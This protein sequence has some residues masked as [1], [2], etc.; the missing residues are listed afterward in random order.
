[1]NVI[2]FDDPKRENLLPFTYTRPASELRLGIYTIREK[3][4]NWLSLKASNFTEDYLSRKFPLKT[5]DHNLMINGR[6]LPSIELLHQIK[7]LK[8]NE[9]VVFNGTLVAVWITEKELITFKS[10][11]LPGKQSIEAKA[12]IIEVEYPWHIFQ[13]NGDQI[14]LDYEW[15]CKRNRSL[16]I[17]DKHTRVYCPENVFLEEGASVKAAILNA[18]NGPIYLGKNST[19]EEGVIIKGPFALGDHSTINMN[20]RMRG[21]ISVG[22]HCKVG[23]EVSNSVFIA[24]SNKGHDGFLGNSVIGEWCNLGA[25]TN[26]SN[27]KNNY[28]NVKLWNFGE[29]RFVDTGLTFCGLM[30]GDHTKCGINTMFNTGTIT[31]VSANIFGSGFPRTLI[32][33]FAW[34][35]SSGFSTFQLKKAFET[36]EKMMERRG[37]VL[38][39]IEKEILTY[40]FEETAKNRIWESK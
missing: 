18:E 8:K 10:Q 6:V 36:A 11:Q 12:P 5:A 26:T 9:Q 25:D 38:D 2:L 29:E 20:A 40:V 31:G 28:A 14:R 1:M 39:D 27:L 7:S 19:V 30:M 35:G 16:P 24:F 4:E 23:G 3:W 21:D 32:P 33:S 17:V 37:I 13:Y 15:I 22:P 34:G